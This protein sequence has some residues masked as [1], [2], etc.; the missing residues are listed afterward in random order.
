VAL[1]LPLLV[2][3]VLGALAA[4]GISALGGSDRFLARGTGLPLAVLGAAGA[5]LVVVVLAALGLFGV[6][7]GPGEGSAHQ[8]TPSTAPADQTSGEAGAPVTA[9]PVAVEAGPDVVLSAGAIAARPLDRLPGKAVLRL[10]ATGFE[11][12][13]SGQVAQCLATLE[14][15]R[16]C[17]NPFPVQFDGNGAA[18][19]QYL[20]TDRVQATGACGASDPPCVVVVSDGDG[21][22]RASVLTVFGDPAPPAGRVTVEPRSGLSG[23]DIVTVRASGFPPDRPLVAAQCPATAAAGGC[24]GSIAGRTGPD[25]A[26]VLQLVV[27]SGDRNGFSCGAGSPCAITVVA[28]AAVPPVATPLSF[29]AGPTARYEPRRLAAG[30]GLALL[31]LVLSAWVVRATDWRGPAEAAT[32]EMDRSVL[33]S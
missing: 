33:D 25:G 18:R 29:A 4:A 31:L 22:V 8:E 7:G 24:D 28:G 20:I 3:L 10:T 14:G 6:R 17:A 9:G 16:S 2:L 15:F 5:G 1:L 13:T 11:P 21:A 12:A 30:L 27:R 26:A 23:D 32:P 19:V